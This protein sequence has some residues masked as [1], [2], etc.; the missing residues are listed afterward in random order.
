MQLMEW[1]EKL[2]ILIVVFA[3]LLYGF[4]DWGVV[5]QLEQLPSPLYGGDYYYQL[6]QI[7]RMYET[8]PVEWL[9]SSNGIGERPGYLPVYGALVTV[10]GKILGLEPMDAMFVFS[11]LVPLISMLA[12]FFLG[13][14]AFGDERVA[15]LIA[16]LLF[17]GAITLK[18]T[19]FAMWAVFPLF[20]GMLF[21]FS[22]KPEMVNGGLLGLVYGVLGLSHGSGFIAGTA[23]VGAV[24]AYMGWKAD[25][26]MGKERIVPYG[27]A[28]VVGIAVAML[29]WFAPIFVYH[30][31]TLLKSEIWSFPY[32]LHDFGQAVGKAVEILAMFF[33]NFGSIN[34]SIRTVLVLGGIYLAWKGRLWE[35]NGVLA[36]AVLAVLAITF[37]FVVT[38][39]LLD[40]QFMPDYIASIYGYTAVALIG[41]F[42]LREVLGRWGVLFYLI[43]ALLIFSG[44]SY[45]PNIATGQY[46]ESAR[47]GLPAEME[48]IY[49]GIK[50]NTDVHDRI[51]STNEVSFAINAMT[52]RELLVSRRAQNEPF[53]D[54][55]KRELAAAVIF[56]GNNLDEKKRLIQEYEVDYIYADYNWVGTEFYFDEVG[57]MSGLFDPLLVLDTTENRA[58]LDA[59]G[60]R[61]TPMVTWIDPSVKGPLVRLY[62]VL[63]IG[64]ENYEMSGYGP[65]ENGLDPH[66]EEAFSQEAGGGTIAVLYRINLG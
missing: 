19:E 1:K 42:A 23:L 49:A 39:P 28:A 25:W 13:K 21:R 41:G 53:V 52:G 45:Y 38:A 9:G 65:W 24:F 22:K 5:S 15:A 2:P 26:K 47:N 31:S 17:P 35:E 43:A 56:Y 29:Y 4:L 61:Y 51:L 34:A 33:F 55:D 60:V 14:E 63:L 11:A 27:V 64:P 54:F 30:G 48:G 66:L 59:N 7:T 20:L 44:Y 18:Y 46:Y 62:D 40:I 12:F 36:V 32:D 3:G 16:L 10:F 50:A 57:Q 37:S 8:G 6:G 58:Y